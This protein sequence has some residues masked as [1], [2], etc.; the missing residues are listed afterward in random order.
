MD[1]TVLNYYISG[2]ITFIQAK[3]PWFKKL[4]HMITMSNDVR[5]QLLERKTVVRNLDKYSKITHD[6]LIMKLVENDSKVSIALDCWTST[7]NLAFLGII[8]FRFMV[9]I[10]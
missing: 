4:I 8:L 1:K 9:L 5:A 10:N 3:N 2:N 7:N 6:D